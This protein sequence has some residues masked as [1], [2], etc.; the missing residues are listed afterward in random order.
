MLWKKVPQ[1][2]QLS[3]LLL[4]GAEAAGSW[5]K[6]EEMQCLLTTV[7]CS[8]VVVV[9]LWQN[10]QKFFLG[11]L[12]LGH[13]S[14]PRRKFPKKFLLL[15]APT[16]NIINLEVKIL[17]WTLK[18]YKNSIFATKNLKSENISSIV[19]FP[20][21]EPAATVVLGCSTR[22]SVSVSS[23]QPGCLGRLPFFCSFFLYP[24]SCQFPINLSSSFWP[25]AI[26]LCQKQA[27]Q[28]FERL[29]CSF[30]SSIY[31]FL[32]VLFFSRVEDQTQGSAL[33]KKVLYHWIRLQI[34]GYCL[35]MIQWYVKVFVL[36]MFQRCLSSGFMPIL[37][38]RLLMV[39]H[40]RIMEHTFK[41]K[42]FK[43]RR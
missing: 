11:C 23:F 24:F 10:W 25:Q 20:L 13:S 1:T 17:A 16:A 18:D 27:P 14:H 39:L 28:I 41:Y 12:S 43:S 36:Q 9:R 7:S 42:L 15:K 8:Q 2:G 19:I 40:L 34:L 38:I 31:C 6:G 32:F 21:S 33:A 3:K 30:P 26:F 29:W 4:I 35:C 5:L 22:S 37:F